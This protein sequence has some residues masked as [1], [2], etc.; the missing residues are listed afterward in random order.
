MRQGFLRPQRDQRRRGKGHGL[1]RRWRGFGMK[2][3]V[4]VPLDFSDPF[5]LNFAALGA[6]CRIVSVEGERAV[7]QRLVDLGLQPGRDI[8]VLRNAPMN[9]P[10][11]IK[12]DDTYVA[13][14]RREAGHI[15]VEYV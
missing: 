13:V 3:H 4:R 12:V 9:D 1:L 15:E 8:V 7:R 14:R 11:E 2:R 6:A 5:N 10:I